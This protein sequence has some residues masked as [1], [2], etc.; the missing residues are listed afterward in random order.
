MNDRLSMEFQEVI[1]T[2]KD[3]Q[4]VNNE[5]MRQNNNDNVDGG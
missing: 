4:D 1:W 3:A 2:Y 5:Q